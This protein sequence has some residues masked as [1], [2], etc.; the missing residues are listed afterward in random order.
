MLIG[1]AS[2]AQASANTP[3]FKDYPAA[4]VYTSKPAPLIIN[5]E[6]AK[7]YKT[8]LNAA[9][10]QKPVY[11]GEYV[12]AS[13][14]CGMTCQIYTFVN[15]KTGQVIEKSFGGETG[16]EIEKFKINSKLLITHETDLESTQIPAA[17]FM[18]FYIIE[19]DKFKLIKKIAIPASQD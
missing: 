14:G 8:R 6:V 4:S 5:N 2:F 12:L 9:L 16:E 19:K 13:W 7:L 3:E 18:N 11:A 1:M 15:K 10:K 17:E